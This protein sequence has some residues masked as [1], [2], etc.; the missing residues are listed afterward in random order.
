MTKGAT[1]HGAIKLAFKF[2]H[3]APRPRV[4]F[5]SIRIGKRNSA[6]RRSFACR[7][8]RGAPSQGLEESI[9]KKIKLAALMVL[10]FSSAAFAQSAPHHRHHRRAP[11]P[12][13]DQY[14][15]IAPSPPM[16]SGVTRNAN[17]C[18]P[19]RAEAVW[20]AGS[21]LVGYSCVTPNAN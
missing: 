10:C 14:S 18:A 5:N 6:P 13:G 15:A 3:P 17:D 12:V 16:A 1:N 9:M 7:I 19:D 20:G 21:A 2:S 4:A 11:A 8:A